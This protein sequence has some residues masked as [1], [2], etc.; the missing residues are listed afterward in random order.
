MCGKTRSLSPNC[1]AFICET[2]TTCDYYKYTK[3]SMICTN[4][5]VSAKH[6][7]GS[8]AVCCFMLYWC[9]AV[10]NCCA[11]N[12]LSHATKKQEA[13]PTKEYYSSFAQICPCREEGSGQSTAVQRWASHPE[14][15]L[16]TWQGC[17]RRVAAAI[18]FVEPLKAFLFL[19]DIPNPHWQEFN[20]SRSLYEII[21]CYF[22][23][24]IN[25]YISC[26]CPQVYAYESSF[27]QVCSSKEQSPRGNNGGARLAPCVKLYIYT[28]YIENSK[29]NAAVQ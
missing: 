27:P 1:T 16:L 29:K 2:R 17:S 25:D 28:K 3:T 15:M 18:Y 11:V 22:S 13:M 7:V 26:P 14:L 20:A 8:P 9:A 4:T 6:A 23:S 21:L 24:R 12:H 19:A 5:K 10:P